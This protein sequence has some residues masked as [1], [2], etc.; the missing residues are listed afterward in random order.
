MKFTPAYLLLLLAICLS[1]CGGSEKK[2]AQI[3]DW[4]EDTKAAILDQSARNAAEITTQLTADSLEVEITYR[5]KGIPVKREWK[6]LQG[7]LRHRI[8]YANDTNFALVNEFCDNGSLS[9]E[10]IE[11]KRK[12]YGLATW[13]HCTNG[14]IYEQGLRCK[15]VK[16]GVWKRF[17]EAGKVTVEHNYKK[18]IRFSDFPEM[19]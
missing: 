9:Y 1:A 12:P 3:T 7:R 17:D 8:L 5:D 2:Y 11:Y 18:K 15:F 13:Y 19:H 14:K 16:M 4:Y 6:D 10:G